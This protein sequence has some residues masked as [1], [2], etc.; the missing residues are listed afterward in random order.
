[1]NSRRVEPLIYHITF[2]EDWYLALEN[3]EYAAESLMREGF[4]HCS[5]RDQVLRTAQALFKNR[6]NLILLEIAVDRLPA[7]V[8]Y[9]AAEN[10]ELFPHVYGSIEV[11]A[12]ER[13]L[14]LLIGMDGRFECNF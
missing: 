8:R 1:M 4:I 13:V 6:S 7:E 5:T 14:P 2:A 11:S 12:V 10:G 3:G 9:E